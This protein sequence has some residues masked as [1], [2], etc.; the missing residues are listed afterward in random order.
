MEDLGKYFVNMI[1]SEGLWEVSQ[2]VG[3]GAMMVGVCQLGEVRVGVHEV[4]GLVDPRAGEQ[5]RDLRGLLQGHDVLLVLGR[6][7]HQGALPG[8]LLGCRACT[9]NIFIVNGKILLKRCRAA[10]KSD[11]NVCNIMISPSELL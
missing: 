8:L 6:R 1:I 11:C 3:D 2:F 10:E 7:L 5:R 9:R 4:R